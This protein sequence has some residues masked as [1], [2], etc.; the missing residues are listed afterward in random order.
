MWFTSA[1]YT[2]SPHHATAV[3]HAVASSQH[4]DRKLNITAVKNSWYCIEASLHQDSEYFTREYLTKESLQDSTLQESTLQES[5]LQESTLNSWHCMLALHTHAIC[6][7]P[8]FWH[9]FLGTHA[10][11]CSSCGLILC[12]VVRKDWWCCH[13]NQVVLSI[14]AR[15]QC[16]QDNWGCQKWDDFTCFFWG[17]SGEDFGQWASVNCCIR[18]QAGIF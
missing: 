4:R 14:G 6:C 15:L 17:N 9:R 12:F 13:G 18:W 10:V 1:K 7:C 11:F 16:G 3:F 8:P 5:T 2:Q